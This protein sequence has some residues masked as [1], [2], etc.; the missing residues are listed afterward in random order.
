MAKI[1]FKNAVLSI[2]DGTTPVNSIDVTIGEGN[3]TFTEKK[4][5]EYTL[6]RGVLNEVRNADQEPMDV[7]FEA[8]W[9]YIT[10]TS[11]GA[12]P[13]VIE[14]LKRTGPAA[15]WV[16]S[17]SDVCRPFA[18]DLVLVYTPECA[19]DSSSPTGTGDI[20][21]IT[22]SDFRYEQIDYDVSAGTFSFTGKCNVTEASV[23]RTPA[24]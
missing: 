7:K 22:L 1:D 23:S 20:E 21:T 14:A 8:T 15:T 12:T 4:A 24:P 10:S 6:D 11:G 19:G 5:R 17:D 13:T 3:L 18:V 2:K 16:S 9:E